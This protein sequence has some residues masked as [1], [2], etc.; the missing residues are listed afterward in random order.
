VLGTPPLKK[1]ERRFFPLERGEAPATP[2]R[3]AESSCS[4]LNREKKGGD[5]SFF[6]K[7]AIPAV[8]EHS[9]PRGEERATLC[10][11]PKGERDTLTQGKKKCG[12]ADATHRKRNALLSSINRRGRVCFDYAILAEEESSQFSSP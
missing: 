3:Y 2:L 11:S 4:L 10:N 1:R 5:P 9:C 6:S 8:S 12:T 7:G